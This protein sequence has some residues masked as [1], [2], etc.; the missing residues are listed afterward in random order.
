MAAK[1]SIDTEKPLKIL[2]TADAVGGVWQYSVDL[3]RGLGESAEI[4]L[5]TLG[6]RPSAEQKQQF[7]GLPQVQL[8]E[9]DYAL[10]WMSNPWRDVD[11]S[12]EWLLSTQAQFKADVIHLNGYAH[13]ALPWRKPVVS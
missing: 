1:A 4:L 8:C 5:A 6:P 7:Q 3:I 2:M 13:A 12:G 9:S 11:A 10:E